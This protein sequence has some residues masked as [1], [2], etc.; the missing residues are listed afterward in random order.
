MTTKTKEHQ[1][2]VLIMAKPIKIK[3]SNPKYLYPTGACLQNYLPGHKL[4]RNQNRDYYGHRNHD[5]QAH[6]ERRLSFL[7]RI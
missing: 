7:Q 3:R 6:Q 1:I 2:N 4:H 5:V